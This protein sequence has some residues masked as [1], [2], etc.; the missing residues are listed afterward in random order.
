MPWGI[1]MRIERRSLSM[2]IWLQVEVPYSDLMPVSLF[3]AIENN[4][5]AH[6]P[7]IKYTQHY[8]NIS[9]KLQ[10]YKKNLIF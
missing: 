8:K 10:Q 2:R 7:P 4:V 6:I 9:L 1:E 3:R 5:H